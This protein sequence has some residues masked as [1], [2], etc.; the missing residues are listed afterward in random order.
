MPEATP[1]ALLFAERAVGEVL[2]EARD[3]GD[4][5]LRCMDATADALGWTSA[6]LWIAAS[7]DRVRLVNHWPGG[8]HADPE[9]LG[10]VADLAKPGPGEVFADGRPRWFGDPATDER[11]AG[12][13]SLAA[14]GVRSGVWFPLEGARR[15]VSVVE[16][17]FSEPRTPDP[18]TQA[19]LVSLGRRVG[20]YVEQQWANRDA[21]RSEARKQAILDAALDTIVTIDEDGIVVEV[22]PAMQRI[23]GFDPAEAVG[24]EMAELI[25]PP[26]LR[27][28]HRAGLRRLVA[29]GEPRLLG[30]RVQLEAMRAD[31][32]RLPVELTVTRIDV[33][34]RPLFTGYVRDITDM[35]EAQAALE[36]SRARVVEAAD[37]ARQR[38]ERDLHDG[39]QQR[40]VALA[41]TLKLAQM[42]LPPDPDGPGAMVAEAID[43]LTAA[44]DEL[45]ELARGMY[46]AVL[47]D[48]GLPSAVAG[49]VRRSPLPVDSRVDVPERLP[50]RVEA[51]A[52]FTI[53]EALANVV[54]HAEAT[55]AEV[56][57]AVTDGVLRFR[58][59]DDGRGG[60][61]LDAGSGLRGLTDRLAAVNGTLRVSSPPGGG[62]TLEATVPLA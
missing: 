59:A 18:G 25:V 14:D 54:R 43:E 56:E 61:S 23:F 51:A 19:S 38:I 6:S 9:R 10:L 11:V 17:H 1:T 4:A 34:G 27:D 47:T 40:L 45:R 53:A 42:Q 39:A 62:T 50:A 26:E 8:P 16:A 15:T 31:G 58:V 37:A 5:F 13:A 35:R 55:H 46:P 24:R 60:A 49:L 3:G 7:R 28:T 57:I 32:S 29:G 2:L 48:A 21:R 30:N 41:L 33:P 22:N 36:A 20:Q 52:Y 44:T 12:G